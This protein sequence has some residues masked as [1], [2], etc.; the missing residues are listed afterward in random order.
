[1]IPMRIAL[2]AVLLVVLPEAA[3]AC[4]VCYGGETESRT[5]FILT[6]VLLSVLPPALVG[7]LVWWIWRQVRESEGAAAD[8]RPVPVPAPSS[9]AAPHA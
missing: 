7:S 6:T 8:A 3:L 2:A 5:A 1:M 4:S 9:S